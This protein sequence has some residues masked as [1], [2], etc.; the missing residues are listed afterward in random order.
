MLKPAAKTGSLA[1]RLLS[2]AALVLV[3][4]AY[5]AWQQAPQPPAA[6]KS[7][8]RIRVVA[9]AKT[10][11]A[12][13]PAHADAGAQ[14]ATIDAAPSGIP[15]VPSA[16]AARAATEAPADAEPSVPS[17][18]PDAAPPPQEAAALPPPPAQDS[19][20][21]AP[22]PLPSPPVQYVLTA[23]PSAVNPRHPR[24]TD[25]DYTGEPAECYWGTVQVEI[26]VKGGAI[27]QVEFLQM[28]DHRRRS[29]EI[30]D[31]AADPLAQEAIQ[32]QVADVD[33]VSSAT[34]TTSAFQQSLRTALDKARK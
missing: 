11:V 22:A 31:W 30:S 3:S 8:T 7:M 5:A 34:N 27:A 32:E 13:P 25:G 1:A 6:V 23:P 28:P 26:Q 20:P 29:A 12:A 14:V 2:S 15:A 17:P 18:L 10:A 24:Y 9:A 16:P 19:A 21:V 4:G 33:I